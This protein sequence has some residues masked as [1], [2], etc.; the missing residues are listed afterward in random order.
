MMVPAEMQAMNPSQELLD[1]MFWERVQRARRTPPAERFLDGPR[2]FDYACRITMA[3][4]R[5]ENP[6]AD[7]QR[8]RE[9]L[10]QRL[11]LQR[12]LEETR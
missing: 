7:E 5:H 12:R 10:E 9:I 4:I 1:E 6:G 11:A 3:G 2:L 8:V